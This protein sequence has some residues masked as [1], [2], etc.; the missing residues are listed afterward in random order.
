MKKDNLKIML[1]RLPMDI[2]YPESDKLQGFHG[3]PN[4]GLHI[5]AKAV[6]RKVPDADIRIYDGYIIRMD[7][8][9]RVIETW[10]PDIVGAT[11][12]YPEHHNVLRFLEKGKSEGALTL[13]GGSNASNVAD[14]MVIN[15]DFIDGVV[16]G[17]GEDVLSDIALKISHSRDY[18]DFRKDIPNLVYFDGE[19]RENEQ[20]LSS[21]DILFD[22]EDMALPNI[23]TSQAV[24]ISTVRGCLKAQGTDKCSYCTSGSRYRTMDPDLMWEQVRL[25]H[26]K[27]G[28]NLFFESG[29]TIANEPL[30]R[31]LIETRPSEL[32]DVGFRVYCSPKQMTPEMAELFREFNV[33]RL[34]LGVES[35]NDELLAAANRNYTV[36]TI[37][38]AIE[39][40]KEFPLHIPFL[41]GFPGETSDTLKN[42][43]DFAK[44]IMRYKPETILLAGSVIPLAGSSLF[45]QM[46]EDEMIVIKYSGDLKKDDLIDYRELVGLYTSFYTDC[47]IDQVNETAEKIKSLTKKGNATTWPLPFYSH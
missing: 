30:L 17:D 47:S 28:Y 25:L 33:R 22:F 41:L 39:N 38:S 5:I 1:A 35:V 34:F 16:K 32:S 40:A 45:N 7:Y 20:K 13:A 11:D 19:V 23:D 15:N 37:Y 24:E 43:L 18:P 44:E 26:D 42:N 14:R 27:Y 21:M 3:A 6:K 46:L 10:K 12:Q 8:L 4:S 2:A 36:E 31:D 29:D 9:A